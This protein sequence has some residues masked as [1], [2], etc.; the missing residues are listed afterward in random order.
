MCVKHPL[1]SGHVEHNITHTATAKDNI[2]FFQFYINTVII[3]NI[4]CQ[5]IRPTGSWSVVM[6]VDYKPTDGGFSYNGNR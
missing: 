2:I 1:T 6:W 5:A 4:I 3:I